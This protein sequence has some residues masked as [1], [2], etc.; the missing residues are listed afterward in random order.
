M[1]FISCIDIKAI[2]DSVTRSSKFTFQCK[3]RL[4]N[5]DSSKSVHSYLGLV[6]CATDGVTSS[7]A[8]L[9]CRYPL[10]RR[11]YSRF[12]RQKLAVLYHHAVY[13]AAA[14]LLRYGLA[15]SGCKRIS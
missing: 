1:L 3:G 5:T 13:G 11:V 9:L 10:R 8:A 15:H 7:G 2:Y 4:A 6:T 14:Y 12:S